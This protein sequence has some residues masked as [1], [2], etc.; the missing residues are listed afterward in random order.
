MVNY[1]KINAIYELFIN[2]GVF[3]DIQ[4]FF[5]SK[6]ILKVF[7]ITLRWRGRTVFLWFRVRKNIKIS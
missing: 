5:I 6:E 2:L 7:A 4:K 3:T 1:F